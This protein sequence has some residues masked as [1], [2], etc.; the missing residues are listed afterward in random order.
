MNTKHF[1]ILEIFLVPL[2]VMLMMFSSFAFMLFFGFRNYHELAL[3]M[4]FS[5]IVTVFI[6]AMLVVSV[7]YITIRWLNN[8]LPWNKVW[9]FRFFADVLIVLLVAF[10][11]IFLLIHYENKGVLPLGVP[12]SRKEYVYILP[13]VMNSFYLVAVEMILSVEIKNKL[14]IRLTQLEKQQVHAK[15][16]ALKSQIDHHFLFNNLSVLSSIIYEDVEKSDVFIQKLSKV[17]RYVLSMNKSDLVSVE[18]EIEFI[19]SYLDLYKFRFEEG[20]WYE[21]NVDQKHYT[22]LIPPLTLQVLI[23]NTIKHNVVSRHQPLKV[24]IYSCQNELVVQNNIQLRESEVES[25]Q[26]GLN[27]LKEK[28]KLLKARIPVVFHDRNLFKVHI[29]LIPKIHG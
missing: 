20:F 23:E 29:S 13:L 4:P 26:T 11:C 15:Y 25:T 9:I 6:Q 12:H 2:V 1:K 19:T 10:S 8:V 27:N 21:I 24:E 17:Y 22:C 28:Y 5:K 14:I 7:F 18:E 16:Q 3:V